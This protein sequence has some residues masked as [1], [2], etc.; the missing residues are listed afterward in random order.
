MRYAMRYAMEMFSNI[1]VAFLLKNTTS[2]MLSLNVGIIKVWKIYYKRSC[3]GLALVR[4]TERVLPV[5]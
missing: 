2:H 1:K 4:L 3:C 5:R